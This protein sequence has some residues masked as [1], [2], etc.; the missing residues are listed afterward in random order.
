M[1][2]I[3]FDLEFNQDFSES[4]PGDG[5]EPRRPCFEIIQIG[6][7]K[8]DPDLN[9]VDTFQSYVKPSIYPEVNPF[10]TELTGITSLQL[11]SAEMFPEIYDAFV[12]F[13]GGSESV[14]CIWGSADL[15]E[16]YRNIEYHQLDHKAL[17]KRYINLQP[18]AAMHLSLSRQKLLKLKTAAEMLDI[19]LLFPFHNALY[20]AQYTAAILKK[21]NREPIRPKRYDPGHTSARPRQVKQKIDFEKLIRQFEKMYSRELTAEERKMVRLAYQMGKTRQFL[22]TT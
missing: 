2:Y 10:V 3:V 14:F 13:T 20:D 15:K 9:A 11:A 6:A 7:V 4:P 21:I 8:L 17:T 1:Y 18:Y 22:K 5:H 16:L 12:E 19:P